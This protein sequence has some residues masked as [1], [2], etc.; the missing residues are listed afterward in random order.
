MRTKVL[1][2]V[3]ILALGAG[4]IGYGVACVNGDE[5]ID[6]CPKYCQ[7]IASTCVG[8]DLQYPEDASTCALICAAMDPGEAGIGGADTVD[9]RELSVSN[10][11]D[12]PNPAS[13][14]NECVLGGL[15]GWV[16]GG[17]NCAAS[18]CEGFCKLD[19]QLCGTQRTGYTDVQDCV[20]TCMTWP[21]SFDGPLI[22]ATGDTLQCRTYHLE[23][24]QSGDPND[25]E[26][27]CPHTAKVSAR[28]FDTDAG[29][30]DGG[31]DAGDAGAADAASD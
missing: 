15:V 4:A 28:C 20:N 12:D 21:Q 31:G 22:G 19:L 14:H 17:A 10:A 2:Y 24:S 27:H 6:P 30:G 5:T 3:A 16:D 23:L 18:A 8:A 11:K 9:C 29:A 25:L 1:A 26:T 13:V 7:D